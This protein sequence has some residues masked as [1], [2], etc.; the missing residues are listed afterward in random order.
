MPLYQYEARGFNGEIVKGKME[1][2]DEAAVI[3]I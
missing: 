2:L 1:A 3:R